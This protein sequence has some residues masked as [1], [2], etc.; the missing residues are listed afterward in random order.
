MVKNNSTVVSFYK[1]IASCGKYAQD[2]GNGLC[3]EI[4]CAL[5]SNSYQQKSRDIVIHDKAKDS[6]EELLPRCIALYN[7]IL[8]ELLMIPNTPF[9]LFKNFSYEIL[10]AKFGFGTQT[11]I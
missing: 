2:G 3:T 5:F 6:D 11:L 4:Y 7:R 10:V 1:P 8:T 9:Q